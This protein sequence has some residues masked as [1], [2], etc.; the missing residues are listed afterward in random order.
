ITNYKNEVKRNSLN[1]NIEVDATSPSNANTSAIDPYHER[2]R[3]IADY[4][5]KHNKPVAESI[6]QIKGIIAS[7]ENSTYVIVLHL[8]LLFIGIFNG[9]A[10]ALLFGR[11]I[12]M[13]HSAYNMKEGVYKDG[14]Y[15]DIIHY[16]TIYILPIYALAQ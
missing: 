14:K 3:I 13:E 4:D 12:S 10:M 2:R 1:E 6:N 16:C 8:F 11:Y 15:N 7:Y 9:L 5:R